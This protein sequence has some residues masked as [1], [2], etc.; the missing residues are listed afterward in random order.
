MDLKEYFKKA[1]K[2]K[3]AIGQFN[4]STLEQ[5]RAI[6]ASAQK[7]KSP[8]ILGTSQGESNFLGLKEI[9]ALTEISKIKYNVPAFLN[10]DHGKDLKVLKSAIDFG[11]S[12]VHFDGSEL[13]FKKNIEQTKKIVEYAHKRG[14]LVEGEL[15]HITGQSKQHLGKIKIKKEDLTLVD[16]VNQFIKQ[17]KVDT[18]AVS[19]GNFHGVSKESPNLDLELLKEIQEQTKTFLVLHGG[20]GISSIDIKKTIKLGIVKINVNTELRMIWKES[21]EKSLRDKK[22]NTKPY[23]ILSNVENL[24][25]K[26]VIEKIK[27]F[28]SNNKY[29]K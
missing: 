28:G 23:S 8:I 7:T 29:E 13:S 6:F 12:A 9:V 1:Q 18:L 2:Q 3:W 19:I 26:K 27:L 4:F 15:G 24:M 25:E 21:L 20:S 14:V 11:Y 22:I 10:F 17:T 16:Q 5:L